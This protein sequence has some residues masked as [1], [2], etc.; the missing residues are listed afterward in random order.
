MTVTILKG[1]DMQDIKEGILH[2]LD[3]AAHSPEVRQHALQICAAAEDKITAIYEWVKRNIYYVS[4]PVNIE[5]F[6][7]PV[8]LIQEYKQGKS[9]A[10]DCDDCA[11][12]VT[13]LCRSVGIPANVILVDSAGEGIDHAIS[14]VW[15][16]KLNCWLVI[17]T[18]S[19][20]PLGW[21]IPYHS[22]III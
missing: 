20:Y 16:E 22:E 12:L 11:I 14:Q 4:D 17:D 1:Y 13:A 18:T 6:T 8:R 3:Q 7:S 19:P 2:Q 9:P 10:G 15:S 21:V 5:L